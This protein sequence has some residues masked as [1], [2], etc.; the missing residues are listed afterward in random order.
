M[1]VPEGLI[2]LIQREER[3]TIASHINPEGDAIGSS[4]ALALALK[5]LNKDV[6]V[7]NTDG[8]PDA[9]AFLPFS[10]MVETVMDVERLRDSVLIV[11]DCNSLERIGID[12]AECK[13]VVVIDH[14]QTVTD[15]GHLRWIEPDSPAAG[16]MVY[17]L[18]R[19]LGTRIDGD[20]AVNLYTAVAVDT[21]TFRY[22]NT[23]A[24][25]LRVAA[26]LVDAGA[27]PAEVSSR[28]YESWSLN[29]FRLFV[30]VLNSLEIVDAGGIRIAVTV[31][32]LGMFRETGTDASDT[33]N[34]INFPRMIGS[35]EISAMFREV[36]P[37]CWKASLRS[38]GGFDVSV[39]ASRFGGGGHRNAAGYT[40]DGNMEDVKRRFVEAVQDCAA[41]G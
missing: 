11:V 31:I 24:E 19:S 12:D 29:K 17:Y 26:D 28:L 20:I 25:V 38:R 23:T 14:H 5:M 18:L 27:D 37:G 22:P 3:F 9:Y 13:G 8:V 34:F 15:F 35:V 7:F 30:R 32:T 2:E 33:E 21:G 1:K 40:V 10:D 4:I 36:E 6:R 41:T 39:I 16:L